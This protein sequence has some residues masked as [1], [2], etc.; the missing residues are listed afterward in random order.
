M[1]DLVVSGAGR[2]LTI[3]TTHDSL[4]SV[5]FGKQLRE[6][7]SKKGIGLK[8]LGPTLGVNYTYLSK[9]EHGETQPSA[10]LVRRIAE[11]FDCDR[12]T[13]LLAAGKV[14]EDVLAILRNN[15]EEALRMLRERYPQGAAKKE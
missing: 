7:R 8:R 3:I 12:D 11:Y 13:L 5:D 1:R 10:D 14:P 6:L 9:L 2:G 15:P 4:F